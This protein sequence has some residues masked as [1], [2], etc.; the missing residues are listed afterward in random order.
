MAEPV[1]YAVLSLRVETLEQE[2]KDLKKELKEHAKEN[3]ED[4]I[5]VNDRVDDL[6]TVTG[7]VEIMFANLTQTTKEMKADIKE[8]AASAGKDQGWR[9]LITD[10]V[11]LIILIIVFVATGKMT[12]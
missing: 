5:E 7:R 3:T 4:F 12:F 8:I 1:G 9:A 6:A 11:K 10:I 2:V